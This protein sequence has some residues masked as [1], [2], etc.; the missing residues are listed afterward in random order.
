MSNEESDLLS[1]LPA[2]KV[3]NAAKRVTR[4]NS[5]QLAEAPLNKLRTKYA[6]YVRLTKKQEAQINDE[7]TF[8][9]FSKGEITERMAILYEM[10]IDLR[11]LQAQIL[12]EEG[13]DAEFDDQ[14]INDVIIKLKAKLHDRLEALNNQ[15]NLHEKSNPTE[16][17]RIE[18]Q[19]TDATGN[20]PNTWGTFNGDYSKW[21]SFRDRW[22]ASMH[23]NKK[24]KTIVK[25]QNLKAAC[26]GAAEGALGEWDLT[27]ENYPKAWERLQ[28]IYEDDYMQVQEFMRKLSKLP[29]MRSAS[30]QSIR[31]VIDTVHKHIHGLKRYIDMNEKHPYVVFA[32]IERMDTDTYRAWEKYR[33]SLAKRNALEGEPNDNPNANKTGKCIPTWAQLE[34]FLEGEVT[35]RVHSEKRSI[36]NQIESNVSNKRQKRFNKRNFKSNNADIPEY[37]VCVLCDNTH[38]IFRCEIFKAMSLVGRINHVEQHKLCVRCLRKGHA[39]P[40]EVKKCNEPCPNCKHT[41]V[42]HNSAICPNVELKIKTAMLANSNVRYGNRKR[43]QKQGRFNAKKQRFNS[44]SSQPNE[45]QRQSAVHKVGDWSIVAKHSNAIKYPDK[46]VKGNKEYT[47]LSATINIR[48]QIGDSKFINCRGLSDTGATLDCI[49]KQYIEEHAL[50]TSKCQRRIL[51]VSGPEIIKQKFICIIRPWF[52]SNEALLTEFFVLSSLEGMYPSDYIE[53]SKD[54]IKNLT[55]ADEKF[56]IPGPINAILGVS[57]YMQIIGTDLYK[58]ADGAIMQSTSFGHIV[59]GRFLV[60]KQ[61]SCDVPVL[62]IS[63]INLSEN[64]AL[65]KA[66][67]RFWSD[68][69]VNKCENKSMLSKEQQ[70]IEDLFINTHYRDESGR[71]VVTM[72]I[73]ED[74]NLGDSKGKAFKQFLQLERKFARDPELKSKYVEVMREYQQL[75]FMKLASEAPESKMH[76]Y[77]PHHAVKRK[78]RVVHNGSSVTS[79]GESLNSIQAIGRKLQYDLQLQIMRFRRQKIGITTDISKMFNR[80]GLNPKQWNLHRLFWRESPNDP[81]Q[82]FVLTVVT[83]GMASSTFNAVRALIQCARDCR[84]RFPEA[85]ETIEKCF[86]ID[87]GTFGSDSIEE[88]KMLCKEVEF[89]LNQGGFFLKGWASNSPQIE[90]VMNATTDNEIIIGKDDETK[91]LGLRWLKNTDEFTIFVKQNDASSKTT[92]RAILSEIS[93]LYDPNGFIAP[94]IIRSKMLMQDIWRLKD[95]QWDDEVSVEIK[96]K[97]QEIHASIPRLNEFKIKRWIGT[98]KNRKIQIHGFCDASDKAYGT[99]IYIRSSDESNQIMI[100][101]LSAKS[102]VAPLKQLSTPRLELQAAVMLSEQIEAVVEAC[103]F[104]NIDVTLW[105]DSSIVISWLRKDPSELK[106]FVANRVKSIQEKTK[107]FK[108]KH[109]SSSDNPADL[110]SRGM[111][112]DEFLKSTFWLEGPS[113]LKLPKSQWPI[114]KLEISPESRTDILKECKTDAILKIYSGNQ[115]TALYDKFQEWNKI[116]NVTVYVL[117]FINKICKRKQNFELNSHRYPT[118]IEKNEAAELWIHFEQSKAYSPEIRRIQS[119]DK[120]PPKSA[121]ASLRPILDKNNMLRVGGRI[122]KANISYE[123]K[124]QYIIPSKSRLSFLILKHAHDATLH[125]GAQV[126]MQF[127]RKKFWIPKLRA[128]AK[129]YIHACVQCVRMAQSTAKQI[130]AELPEIRLRPAH[131]FQHVGVDMA[132]PYNVRVTNKINMNTR[133]RSP[134]E[135]KAWIAVFVCLV[136]RSIHLEPTEG[137]SADDFLQAYQRFVS[138]RGNPEKIYSDNGTNFVGADKLLQEAF[139]KWKAEQIQYAVHL[140]GTEW[141]FITPSAPHEG[142]IWEAAVKSMKHHLKR[143]MGTQKYSIQGITTLLA[144][145]EACLNSR[146]LCKL[147]DDPQDLEALTPAHF[148]IGRSLRLPIHEKADNPPYNSKRLFM[149]L[150][151]QVQAFW[152]QWSSDY[153]QSLSQMPK[154][155]EEHE[156]VKTGQLVL[157]KSDNIPPTYWAMGRIIQTSMGNDGKVRSVT[158]KTHSG[159]LERSIRKLCILPSDIELSYWN[160]GNISSEKAC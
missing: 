35:I 64:E 93:K 98:D 89:I 128:E 21:K 102:K 29:Q 144:S 104:K 14:V 43:K 33:P 86:Y 15:S 156:N 3:V 47:I 122:D 146:P 72:P 88:A 136:T 91:I 34:E 149:Q 8:N 52:E 36:T 119:G 158:I 27:D 20:V 152:K 113:W 70:A 24:V 68:E 101:L 125:G 151:F 16:P 42:Y 61:F 38:A 57:T 92:K 108:W 10:R 130:M 69:D 96:R 160:Q 31:D 87:D 94:F 90:A 22:M 23:D 105:S 51:G 32:V 131:P 114:P 65:E 41:V 6:F 28:A 25:F 126:M 71:Y 58:H 17:F 121:I 140:N 118:L 154:W 77:L 79:S 143:I 46:A 147:S 74:R 53:A 56:D 135:I 110:V 116:L 123:A 124:H 138:R 2:G 134:P 60:K 63:N 44:T 39:G 145:I 127:I 115:K 54:E 66:L 95:T 50:R 129:K 117:R 97:W 30:S 40:C 76:Y 155:R 142:G 9:A 4:S 153:L 5:K 150:Q 120:L 133:S 26:V 137:M 45:N 55:L 109:I 82:E 13:D 37:L 84:D 106:A 99:S 139:S 11:E 83:F 73:K 12:S 18:V 7:A 159:T 132:G 103:E 48:I 19:Q 49:T 100:S 80:V 81:I 141:R 1:D 107:H 148:L 85:S 78:F 62:S 59:L 111:K 75:G 157:I 67:C 112:M